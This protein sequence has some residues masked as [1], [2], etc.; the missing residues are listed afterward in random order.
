MSIINP[1]PPKAA[2]AAER[3]VFCCNQIDILIDLCSTLQRSI[4]ANEEKYYH[5][6]HWLVE[7]MRGELIGVENEINSVRKGVLL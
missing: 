4:N 5:T 2:S 3:L 6:D 1:S 7:I